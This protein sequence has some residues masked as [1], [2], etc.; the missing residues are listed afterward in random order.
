MRLIVVGAGVNEIHW[1]WGVEKLVL[2]TEYDQKQRLLIKFPSP[3]LI[4]SKP[5]DAYD[6]DGD[7]TE[8]AL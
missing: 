4:S 7:T 6:V 2:S 8:G 1:G 5:A 3:R